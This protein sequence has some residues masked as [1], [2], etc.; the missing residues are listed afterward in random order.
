MEKESAAREQQN[1]FNDP[2][3]DCSKKRAARLYCES[4]H[5]T[6]LAESFCRITTRSRRVEHALARAIK[7]HPRAAAPR[8][9]GSIK[10]QTKTTQRVRTNAFYS[11][12]RGE[13]A[14]SHQPPQ[15]TEPSFLLFQIPLPLP[16]ASG[17]LKLQPCLSRSCS[18]A[19]SLQPPL[20]Q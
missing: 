18:P 1:L 15:H 3:N 6:L 11:A 19:H 13:Q 16:S 14:L 7:N 17:V 10:T 8:G 5:Q 2:W 9:G 20:H 4:C 12:T